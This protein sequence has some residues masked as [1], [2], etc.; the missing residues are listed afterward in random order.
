MNSP[1]GLFRFA[2]VGSPCATLHIRMLLSRRGP[3]ERDG[4]T[5]APSWKE[6]PDVKGRT[7]GEPT[8][9]NRKS[10]GGEFM[11]TGDE[12]TST[13]GEF[14]GQ[15]ELSERDERGVRRNETRSTTC[16]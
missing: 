8:V 10:P 15:G 14:T 12:F 5:G 6:H 4:F 2:T 3:C 11:S 13:G 16:V 1:P 7:Q 9:A